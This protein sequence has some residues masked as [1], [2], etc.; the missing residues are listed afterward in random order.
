M[1]I[2]RALEEFYEDVKPAEGLEYRVLAKVEREKRKKLSRILLV[3]TLALALVSVLLV[4]SHIGSTEYR[5]MGAEERVAVS[6]KKDIS[7]LEL[8]KR[9]T[10]YNLRIEGPYKGKFYIIGDRES[11]ERFLKESGKYFLVKG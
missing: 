3:E 11:I 1:S 5:T 4:Y 8:S 6:V 9:L 2:K 10:K 7:L